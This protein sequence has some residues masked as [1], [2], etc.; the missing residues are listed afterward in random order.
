MS[1]GANF[2]EAWVGRLLAMPP[3]ELAA[4]YCDPQPRE[5]DGEVYYYTP[6]AAEHELETLKGP[7][8]PAGDPYRKIGEV[9]DELL[10]ELHRRLR[11][12]GCEQPVW[13]AVAS[14]LARPLPDDVAD[15][16]LDRAGELE[17]LTLT[18][19]HTRQGDRAQ[20]RLAELV[21]EALLTLGI[22][23]YRD[24]ERDASEL[25]SLLERFRDRKGYG[26]LLDTLVRRDP[27]SP[28]KER[29]L[30][31]A[32]ER[33]PEREKLRRTMEEARLLRRAADPGIGVDEA[34]A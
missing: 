22:E 5:E 6:D 7:Y 27:S 19:G 18:L 32:V 28:E 11:G 24:P 17:L 1:G 16:F 12:T 20:W 10:R 33:H 31:E 30:R 25:R 29:V 21:E 13:C 3:A 4:R 26:W 14:E 15:D 8:V 34:R 9:P 23:F 2:L